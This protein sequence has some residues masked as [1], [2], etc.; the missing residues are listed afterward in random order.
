M[1]RPRRPSRALLR[2]LHEPIHLDGV[3][4][5]QKYILCSKPSCEKWHG[6]YWYAYYKPRVDATAPKKKRATKTRSKYV[7][8]EL[9]ASVVDQVRAAADDARHIELEVERVK[10]ARKRN[11]RP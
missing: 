6:P 11:M 9:P 3:T 5:Q 2:E 1:R 10:R 8:R 7:G 4:Y